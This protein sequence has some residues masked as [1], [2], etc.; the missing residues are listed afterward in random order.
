MNNERMIPAYEVKEI[1]SAFLRIISTLEDEDFPSENEK[2]RA[3]IFCQE[4]R[5]MAD[6]QSFAMTYKNIPKGLHC[7]GQAEEMIRRLSLF[8]HRIGMYD[9]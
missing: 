7:D 2:S 3:E 9:D 4:V 8:F 5:K 1:L 6:C